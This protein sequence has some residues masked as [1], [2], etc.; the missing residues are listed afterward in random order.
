MVKVVKHS[1]IA[2]EIKKEYLVQHL[3]QVEGL[4]DEWIG[5]LSAPEPFSTH[6]GVL[7]WES[8]YRPTLEGDSDSNHMLRSH[9]RSR[10]LWR[11]HTDW[12]R[13]LDLA[14]SLV[15]QLREIST[16]QLPLDKGSDAVGIWKSYV[17][18]ALLGA[19]EAVRRNR[20]VSMNY[21]VPIDGVGVAC[22]DFKIDIVAVT[23]EQRKAAQEQHTIL[24]QSV[25]HQE[26]MKQLVD[27]W[28]E[29]E[30]IEDHMTRLVTKTLKS[31]DILYPCRFCRHLWK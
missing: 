31:R 12:E 30:D 23:E 16:G 22:G 10:A 4:I 7:G 2:S 3:E 1:A 29:I 11:H 28:Q 24:A 20:R 15:S 13:Q 18:T 25:S 14:W 6:D 8:E 9:V 21:N 19:F 17:G 26:A 5:Q 27:C